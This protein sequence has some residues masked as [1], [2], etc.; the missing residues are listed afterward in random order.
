MKKNIKK[1][2]CDN[3]YPFAARINNKFLYLIF[4]KLIFFYIIFIN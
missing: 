1:E 3:Y 4:I 2:N